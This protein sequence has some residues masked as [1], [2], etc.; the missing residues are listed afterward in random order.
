MKNAFESM[1]VEVVVFSKE[2]AF[3]N[4]SARNNTETND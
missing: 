4:V 3:M 1:C 2:E